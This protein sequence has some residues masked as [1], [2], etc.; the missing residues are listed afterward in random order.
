M[1]ASIDRRSSA[2]RSSA[3]RSSSASLAAGRATGSRQ[4]GRPR[5]SR[6][7]TSTPGP[8]WIGDAGRRS[9]R[10][11]D[12]PRGSYRSSPAMS[13]QQDRLPQSRPSSLGHGA[14]GEALEHGALRA[15]RTAAPPS[16]TPFPRWSRAARCSTGSRCAPGP[17]GPVGWMPRAASCARRPAKVRRGSAGLCPRH[18]ESLGTKRV[19]ESLAGDRSEGGVCARRLGEVGRSI[20][21]AAGAAFDRQQP[22]HHD[23]SRPS[24]TCAAA[25]TTGSAWAHYWR[26]HREVGR[27]AERARHRHRRRRAARCGWRGRRPPSQATA[28]AW[29][30]E[31]WAHARVARGAGA[32]ELPRRAHD[33]TRRSAP[34]TCCCRRR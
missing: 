22:Q 30:V 17:G 8:R 3:R 25:V 18:P 5:A 14:S 6:A 32:R 28:S 29:F 21:C 33:R 34:S 11:P 26:G 15:R 7:S 23:S 24:S 13:R 10:A 27:G 1:S 2:S 19:V 12:R 9:S 31:S 4:S 16:A 20:R